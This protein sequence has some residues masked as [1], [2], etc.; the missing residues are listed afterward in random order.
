MCVGGKGGASG[1]VLRRQGTR[2][3]RCALRQRTAKGDAASAEARESLLSAH[4]GVGVEDDEGDA[5]EYEPARARTRAAGAESS[6][7]RGLRAQDHT[8]MDDFESAA[9]TGD[10]HHDGCAILLCHRARARAC[11]TRFISGSAYR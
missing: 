6:P 2:L 9:D 8:T 1:N 11:C 10:G 3:M 5:V 4:T 7:G